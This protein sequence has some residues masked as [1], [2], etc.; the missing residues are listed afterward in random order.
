MY[1]VV[2]GCGGRI[3]YDPE[4]KVRYRQHDNNLVGIQSGWS[5]GMVRLRMLFLRRFQNWNDINIDALQKMRIHLTPENKLLLNE[6]ATARQKSFFP[7]VIGLK[8]CGIHRQ[9]LLGNIGLIAASIL[10]KM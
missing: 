4:P 2:S 1:M 8:R 5:A 7:R 6:F 3:F 9:T 10:K